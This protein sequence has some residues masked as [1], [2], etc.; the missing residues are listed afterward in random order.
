M[1]D[2]TTKPVRVWAVIPPSGRLC[3]GWLCATR[4]AAESLRRIEYP[5][6]GR[7]ARVAR[8]RIVVEDGKQ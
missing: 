4:A 7:Q 3:I 2:R 1:Q 5:G 8:V 6:R